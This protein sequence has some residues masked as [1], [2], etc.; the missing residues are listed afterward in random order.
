MSDSIDIIYDKYIAEEKLK[1]GTKY[2]K[3]V[4]VVFKLLH[5]NDTVIHDLRL[6]GYEKKAQHQIDVTIEKDGTRKKILIECKDYSKNIG[7]GIIRDFY[8]AINQ[9]KPDDAFVVTT[10]GYTKGA[11]NFAKDESIK[12]FLLKEFRDKDWYGKMRKFNINFNIT[13]RSPQITGIIPSNEAETKKLN[14]VKKLH[15]GELYSPNKESAFF[16]DSYGSII[17]NFQQIIVPIFKTF[18]EE[19]KKDPGVYEFDTPMNIYIFETL[20]CIKGF[21]YEFK[22]ENFKEIIDTGE[23]IAILLLKSLDGSLNQIIFDKDLSKWD[24]NEKEVV[25]KKT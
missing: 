2:E 19:M 21:N 15:K 17:G 24:F 20:V 1:N 12:L 10:V 7:I 8:G 25:S 16:Y 3:L 4:A 9:I 14:L 11:V 13:F 23:M 18:T 22:N 5:E 6:R